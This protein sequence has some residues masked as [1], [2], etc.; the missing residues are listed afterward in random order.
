MSEQPKKLYRSKTDRIIAGVCGGLAEYV[1]VDPIIIRAAFL[2]LLFYKGFGFIVYIILA[3]IV[4][5]ATGERIETDRKEKIQEFAEG[6]ATQ[7]QSLAQEMKQNQGWLANRRNMFGVVLIVFG[8]V[9]IA[10]TLL[11]YQWMQ[12]ELIWPVLVIAIGVYMIIKKG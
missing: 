11:P 10:E 3:I 8:L 9:A 5:E 12:W 4:P 6:I 2:A 7:A 1:N